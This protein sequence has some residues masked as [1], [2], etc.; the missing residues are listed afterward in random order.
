MLTLSA[1]HLTSSLV[2]VSDKLLHYTIAIFIHNPL[3]E[4][5]VYRPPAIKLSLLQFAEFK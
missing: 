4:Y 5:S 1:I 3:Q 2:A